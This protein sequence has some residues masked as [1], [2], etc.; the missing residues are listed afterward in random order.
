[1]RTQIAP[2]DGN[3]CFAPVTVAQHNIL[4]AVT[5]CQIPPPEHLLH[6]NVPWFTAMAY[7]SAADCNPG[8]LEV[9][10]RTSSKQIH[11]LPEPARWQVLAVPQACSNAS[12]TYPREASSAQN[13]LYVLRVPARPCENRTTGKGRPVFA[14]AAPCTSSA[15]S[16]VVRQRHIAGHSRSMEAVLAALQKQHKQVDNG[17]RSL[18]TCRTLEPA[19]HITRGLCMAHDAQ[20]QR[21]GA[22]DG[23]AG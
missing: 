9:L 11:G 15:R 17:I 16:L 2:G 19:E 6:P 22:P 23:T 7:N 20:T 21:S 14:K 13:R 5:P 1:M 12:T 4:A 8:T 18:A 3:I 10:C